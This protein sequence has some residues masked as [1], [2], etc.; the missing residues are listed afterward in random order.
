MVRKVFTEAV[1]ERLERRRN[2]RR[3]DL[4]DKD[5]PGLAI[6]V[7]KEKTFILVCRLPNKDNP[8]RLTIGTYPKMSVDEARTTAREWNVYIRNGL[9]PRV[10]LKQIADQEETKRR[11]TFHSLLVDYMSTLPRR[12]RNRHANRDIGLFKRSLLNPKHNK[13][14]ETPAA[15]VTDLHITALIEEI[16]DRPA[17]VEAIQCLKHLRMCFRWARSPKR[18]EHY[19]INVNPT[20]EL[21]VQE[22]S[23]FIRSRSRHL[24]PRE[25]RALLKAIDKMGYPFGSYCYMLLLTGQRKDDV[26]GLTW[27]E[28][29]FHENLWTIP[30]ARYKTGVDQFVP[31]SRQVRD[32]L[33]DIRQGLPGQ[34]GP[35]VFSFTN[36][37]TK[38]NCFSRAVN[39]LR[40]L[41]Q[42]EFS[43][44]NPG[45]RIPHWTLHDFRRTVRTKLAFLQIAPHVSEAVLGHGKIGIQKVYDQYLYLGEMDDALQKWADYV[46]HLKASGQSPEIGDNYSLSRKNPKKI[47]P[48]PKPAL[49]IDLKRGAR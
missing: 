10:A 37:T 45:L 35:F 30:S 6:R 3:Y 46:E 28:I 14:L 42:I 32:L 16:R 34:Y 49:L 33:V 31:L 39:R 38:I 11:Q 7:G 36:G 22:L 2:G 20:A 15:D 17:R 41:G 1:I 19:G 9:D 12:E 44:E 23:L 13:F 29:N 27:A 25:I 48:K 26:A 4:M 5:V 21:T 43:T 24:D 18:R 40:E 8:S 47:P